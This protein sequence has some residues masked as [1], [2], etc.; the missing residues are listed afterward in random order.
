MSFKWICPY[1]SMTQTVVDDQTSKSTAPIQ[2]KG[3]AEGNI[4]V[5]AKSIGCSNPDCLR[6]TVTVRIGDYTVGHDYRLTGKRILFNQLVA[7]E[8]LEPPTRGL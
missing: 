3:K 5:E 1:C 6:T 7:E 4:A 2:I 8:G